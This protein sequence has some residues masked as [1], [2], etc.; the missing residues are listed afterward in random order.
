MIK[1]INFIELDEL[2]SK[3]S[4]SVKNQLVI[5]YADWC[6][7]CV[8]NIPKTKE[9]LD[10]QKFKDAI[11]V[12]ISDESLDVWEEDGNTEWAVEVVPT[13]RVYKNKKLVSDHANVI[14]EKELSKLIKSC[15]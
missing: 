10:K 7:Y 15:K 8:D 12:N 2:N 4:N 3:L 9:I 14:D 11:F 5:F 13:Y 1:N 6:P